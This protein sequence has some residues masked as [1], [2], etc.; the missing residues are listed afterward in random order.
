MKKVLRA[1]IAAYDLAIQEPEMAKLA[2]AKY[3]RTA[4]AEILEATYEEHVKAFAR[5]IPYVSLSGL[6]SIVDF[7]AEMTPEVRKL[8][9]EKMFDNFLLQE[10][11]REL[12][13]TR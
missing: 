1:T 7:R 2:L 13:Q 12:P 4:D 9:V 3:T 5:R 10:L 11:V 8:T 6:T